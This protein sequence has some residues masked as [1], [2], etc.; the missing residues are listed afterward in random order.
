MKKFL[1]EY[2]KNVVNKCPLGRTRIRTMSEKI[3]NSEARERLTQR[4]ENK[5]KFSHKKNFQAVK[6]NFFNEVHTVLL[7]IRIQV[8]AKI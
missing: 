5:G 2:K 4:T 7:S 3:Y 1:S 6:V 8:D